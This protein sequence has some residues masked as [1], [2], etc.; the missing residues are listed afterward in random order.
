MSCF[1]ETCNTISLPFSASFLA[2]INT[3]S[4]SHI[5]FFRHI[6]F[7]FK[8]QNRL[9]LAKFIS[10][11]EVVRT[12][13]CEYCRFA[14]KDCI[15]MKSQKKCV[16]CIRRGCLCVSISLEILNHAFEKLQTQLQTA[17]KEFVRALF[18]VNRLRK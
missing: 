8:Y 4:T 5:I 3:R 15:V 10:S 11:R 14:E 7:F 16:E 1:Y 6:M 17:E 2:F 18:R 12:S 13:P 9:F